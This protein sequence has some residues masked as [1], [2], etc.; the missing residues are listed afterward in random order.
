MALSSTNEP[1]DFNFFLANVLKNDVGFHS[2]TSSRIAH[3]QETPTIEILDTHSDDKIVYQITF[4]HDCRY[5]LGAIPT[6]TPL[7]AHVRYKFRK[8]SPLK[9]IKILAVFD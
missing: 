4:K 3:A 1:F 2:S 5:Y 9:H 7:G 8:D 6:D